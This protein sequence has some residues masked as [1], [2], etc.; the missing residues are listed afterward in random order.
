[1]TEVKKFALYRRSTS[2]QEYILI[3]S[4]QI[5]VEIYRKNERNK[6]EL[7]AYDSGDEIELESINLKFSIEQLFE[8]IIF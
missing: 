1:M 8:D 6:W 5:T 2:L 7:T 4:E 3:G